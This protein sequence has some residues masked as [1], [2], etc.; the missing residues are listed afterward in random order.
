MQYPTEVKYKSK[1]KE[2]DSLKYGRRVKDRENV[3]TTL[4]DRAKKFPS[5][6]RAKK[7]LKDHSLRNFH[8]IVSE[9]RP[10]PIKEDKQ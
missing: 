5:R 8:S 4:V 2:K 3:S 9:G 6:T 7:F 1:F 10:E